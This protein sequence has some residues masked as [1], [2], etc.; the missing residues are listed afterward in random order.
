MK[1]IEKTTCPICYD[2]KRC[3]EFNCGHNFC[4]PCIKKLINYLDSEL[5]LCPYGRCE[6]NKIKNKKLDSLMKNK[7]LENEVN[8]LGC[9]LII[10]I[11]YI[12][13]NFVKEKEKLNYP[14]KKKFYT[15][16]DLIF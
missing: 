16:Q 11:Y 13:F 10:L 4:K 8:R 5:L 12:N 9:T 3:I 15:Y 14:E 1:H 7:I 6:V 2:K